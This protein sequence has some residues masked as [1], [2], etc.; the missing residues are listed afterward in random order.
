MAVDVQ[1]QGSEF[2]AGLPHQIFTSPGGAWPLD[3]TLD[4]RILAGVQAD[5]EVTPPLAL[6]LNWDAEMKK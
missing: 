4:G 5:Q 2:H 1:P 6:V 3:T